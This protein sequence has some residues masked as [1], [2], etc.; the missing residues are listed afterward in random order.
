MTFLGTCANLPYRGEDCSSFL[1]NG[2]YLV[3]TGWYATVRMLS[4]GFDPTTVTH[5]LITH[6]HND[7]VLGLPQILLYQKIK[8]E[9]EG[10]DIAPLVVAGPAADLDGILDRAIPTLQW[11]DSAILPE[12]KILSPS[13]EWETD[14][15][16]I[17][18]CASRHTAPGLVYRF[19]DRKTGDEIGF[20]GDTSYDPR[21]ADHLQGVSLLIH[22]ACYNDDDPPDR[23]GLHSSA[24][25]AAKIAKAAGA[26]RLALIH[27]TPHFRAQKV[28]IARKIFSNTF[29]PKDGETVDVSKVATR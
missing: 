15:F 19:L 20:T 16:R 27:A 8:R 7:H 3:D 2:R 12:R 6:R 24:V 9:Q 23:P 21:I 1:I 22:D 17:R 13:E 14:E 29:W 11:P 10:L 25:H 18:V 26:K 4:F 5:L 28:A